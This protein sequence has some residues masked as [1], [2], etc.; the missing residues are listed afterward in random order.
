MVLPK[1]IG[2]QENEK[3]AGSQKEEHEC[4]NPLDDR[5]I[6]DALI[7]TADLNTESDGTNSENEEA[8]IEQDSQSIDLSVSPI[9]NKENLLAEESTTII[10]EN[11]NQNEKVQNE[12]ENKAQNEQVIPKTITPIGVDKNPIKPGDVEQTL[13]QL[14]DLP[15]A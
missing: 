6:E 13:R 11:K 7:P 4:E 10:E 1:G 9:K 3:S 2:Y 5:K 8:E 12:S 14:L 15:D